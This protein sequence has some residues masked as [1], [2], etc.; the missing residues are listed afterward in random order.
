M[1][2]LSMWVTYPC[3]DTVIN[4]LQLAVLLKKKKKIE[5]IEQCT[6]G[7]GDAKEDTKCTKECPR[8][9]KEKNAKH[10][11]NIT[12]LEISRLLGD[13]QQQTVLHV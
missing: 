3:K 6:G 12:T 10:G 11:K 4:P 5:A 1:L 2:F 7:K 8:V 9:K 13:A